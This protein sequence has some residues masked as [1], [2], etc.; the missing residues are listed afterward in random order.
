MNYFLKVLLNIRSLRA[1]VRDL[2][3]EQLLEIKEKFD[4][5]V[6]E[7]L[8]AAEAEHAAKLE[9]EKKLAEFREL[10]VT[11]GISAED[12]V[13]G[14]TGGTASAASRT[15]RAPRPAKYAYLVDGEERTWTGQGRMPAQMAAAI[16]AGH[17][18]LE[19]FLISTVA[20]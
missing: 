4:S 8:K 10:M 7:Q 2:P 5:V 6:Q 17:K 16:E 12:L 13:G 9:Y 14:A 20:A 15:K 18:T 1:A 19:D 3:F 11:E